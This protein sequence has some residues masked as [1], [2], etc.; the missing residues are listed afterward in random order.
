M[1][2]LYY[3]WLASVLSKEKLKSHSFS[4]DKPATM[5]IKYT[6]DPIN[7]QE[8]IHLTLVFE[9]GVRLCRHTHRERNREYKRERA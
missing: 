2:Q 4:F 3:H 8:T 7:A 9:I 5:I 6:T 1:N